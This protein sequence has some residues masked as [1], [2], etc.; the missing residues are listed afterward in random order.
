[1]T[2]TIRHFDCAGT[3]NNQVPDPDA[4]ATRGG[5]L[6]RAVDAAPFDDEEIIVAAA[7]PAI[8]KGNAMDTT[9]VNSFGPPTREQAKAAEARARQYRASRDTVTAIRI[10][11]ISAEAAK[12]WAT[13]SK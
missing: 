7:S 4:F 10:A 5:F 11:S 9:P 8:T 1:M 3:R 2:L 13:P 12:F 6:A